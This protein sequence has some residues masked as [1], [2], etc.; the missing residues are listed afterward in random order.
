MEELGQL[1]KI[2]LIGTRSCDLPACRIVP[3]PTPLPRPLICRW[4]YNI[5][6]ELR[7][8]GCEDIG[9]LEPT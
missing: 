5:K 7:E 3:Q 1:K 6:M 4:E 8:V 9:W 2:H